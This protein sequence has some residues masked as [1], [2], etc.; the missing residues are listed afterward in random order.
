[1]YRSIFAPLYVFL[2]HPGNSNR[3]LRRLVA[4]EHDLFLL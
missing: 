1:M 4:D 2:R 3:I